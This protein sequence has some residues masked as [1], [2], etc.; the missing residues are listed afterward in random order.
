M[1]GIVGVVG[2]SAVNQRIYDGLTVLQHRGQDAAGIAT[3]GDGG[4]CVRKGSG[5]VRD[6]FQQEHMLELKGH[7]GIG[8]VR[9]PTAGC[10]GIAEAQPFYVNAPYGI[11]LAHNGNLTNAAELAEII[12]REDR[13]HL[14]TSSDSEVLLNVFA[15]ELQRIGTPRI[16]PAD[17]FAALNAVY[18]RC[19]GG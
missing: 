16:T 12:S 1:C 2:T 18:R 3:S 9:Y 8:H 7:V 6:V 14:N 19:R 5:L 17:V 13:R 11:C 10:D 4:L 15:S